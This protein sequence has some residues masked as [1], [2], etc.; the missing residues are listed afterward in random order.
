MHISGAT[1]SRNYA[2]YITRALATPGGYLAIGWGG[3]TLYY[4]RGWPSG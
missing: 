2:D 1:P 3:A 4:D